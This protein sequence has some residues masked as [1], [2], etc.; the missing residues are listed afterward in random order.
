MRNCF[1]FTQFYHYNLKYVKIKYII[2]NTNTQRKVK[3]LNIQFIY[4]L[5]STFYFISI[6]LK[7][8]RTIYPYEH[9]VGVELFSEIVGTVLKTLKL[10]LALTLA[11]AQ[12]QLQLELQLQLQPFYFHLKSSSR[13]KSNLNV[14]A[15][16]NF[17]SS[18]ALASTLASASASA[19]IFFT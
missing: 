19:I 14:G 7:D 5:F 8:C 9:P 16:P 3:Y 12:L 6:V 13:N 10:G 17:S 4:S 18:S 15:C 2:L 11:L 1:I